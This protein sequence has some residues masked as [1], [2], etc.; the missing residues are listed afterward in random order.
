MLE[1]CISTCSICRFCQRH[2]LNR[3]SPLT[4]DQKQRKYQP[5][6]KK[7]CR[8]YLELHMEEDD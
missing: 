7:K 8:G 4:R 5:E 3:P 1:T 6:L 2:T